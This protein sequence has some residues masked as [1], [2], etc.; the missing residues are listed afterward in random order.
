MVS[1]NVVETKTQPGAQQEKHRHETGASIV[2]AESNC[3]Q[4]NL[5]V[6]IEIRLLRLGKVSDALDHPSV[7]S[8]ATER[9][10]PLW[11]GVRC[12]CN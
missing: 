12:F 6:H 2:A 5:P 3:S 4:E 7:A 9:N 8:G 11:S 10:D 1:N